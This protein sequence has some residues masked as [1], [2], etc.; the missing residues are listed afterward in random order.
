[1]CLNYRSSL[2]VCGLKSRKRRLLNPVNA[3]ENNE[4]V[5][6]SGDRLIYKLRN[7]A[8]SIEV[9]GAVNI[10]ALDA[11]DRELF[12]VVVDV[13]RQLRDDPPAVQSPASTD[14]SALPE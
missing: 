14:N 11:R 10:F 2:E 3:M 6:G 5:R 13:L 9:S 7:G 12:A 8:G 1:M 4:T